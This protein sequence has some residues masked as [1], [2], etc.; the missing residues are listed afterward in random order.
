MKRFLFAT[1]PFDGHFKPLT[2][3]ASHLRELGHDVRWY[4]GPSYASV[5]RDLDIPHLPFEHAR[6]VNGDNI[7]EV[8]PERVKLSG[9]KLLAFEFENI[10]TANCQ[11]RRQRD[12]STVP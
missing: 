5:L 1:M 12:R 4:A 2:G 6:E 11:A 10:F 9:P 7:A 3:L 8:F